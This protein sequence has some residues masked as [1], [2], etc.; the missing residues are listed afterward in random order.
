M[1]EGGSPQNNLE[2]KVQSLE[3]QIKNLEKKNVQYENIL[4]ASSESNV[5]F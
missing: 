2:L 1:S 4:G 5:L 3:I